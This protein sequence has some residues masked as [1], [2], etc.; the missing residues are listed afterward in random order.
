MSLFG[1]ILGGARLL[2]LMRRLASEPGPHPTVVEEPDSA[3]APDRPAFD[4]YRP[5]NRPLGLTLAVHGVTPHGRK[6]PRIIHFARCLARSGVACA[7]PTLRG[8]AACQFE[9]ADLDGLAALVPTLADRF[10]QPAG[11]IGFSY[12]GSFSLVAAARSEAA[13]HT[14]FVISVGGYHSLSELLDLYAASADPEPDDDKAWDDQIYLH[15]VMAVMLHATQPQPDIL[16]RAIQDLMHRYCTGSSPSEK[17]RFFQDRLKP[18][19]LLPRALAVLRDRVDL[20]AFSPEGKLGAIPFPVSLLHD[21]T[22]TMV[23]AAHAHRLYREVTGSRASGPDHRLV[24]TRLLDHVRLGDLGHPREVAHLVR[25]LLPAVDPA[26]A[27]KRFYHD[28]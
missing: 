2:V 26:S 16:I 1:E 8:M 10:E 23:P 17:R 5:R 24:V 22:D 25:A 20:C 11:L 12:G 9:V 28:K 27:S 14:R 3:P 6:D 19:G 13:P 15:L 21:P 4:L 18:C 7:V